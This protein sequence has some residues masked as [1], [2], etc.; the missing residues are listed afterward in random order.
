MPLT[1]SYKILLVAPFGGSHFS[2]LENLASV[3]TDAGHSVLIT[4]PEL[5]ITSRYDLLQPAPGE[6]FTKEERLGIVGKCLKHIIA[7][8]TEKGTIAYIPTDCRS[9]KWRTLLELSLPFL[10]STHFTEAVRAAAPNLV[11]SDELLIGPSATLAA[12]LNKPLVCFSPWANHF[13]PRTFRGYPLL[14]SREPSV[15]WPDL[16]TSGWYV[17]GYLHALLCQR[18]LERW[19]REREGDANERVD[20]FMV[21]DISHFSYPHYI[22]PKVALVGG[23][24]LLG[25][26]PALTPQW[27]GK[28]HQGMLVVLS[29]GSYTDPSWLPWFNTLLEG[30]VSSEAGH[31]IAKINSNSS[32]LIQSEKITYTEWIP[33]KELLG[34]GKVS[35]FVSHCGQNSRLEAAFYGVP[36]LCIPL[37]GDQLMNAHT[38]KWRGFGEVL[39]KEELT[40][41]RVKEMVDGML[42]DPG[43]YRKV[44]DRAGDLYRRDPRCGRASFLFQIESLAELGASGGTCA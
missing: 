38:V 43:K 17:G 16:V 10:T 8:Q 30:I 41:G 28:A 2:V 36:I 21:N 4:C 39:L 25:G 33:Q 18:R 7:G 3:L 15:V 14:I 40:A 11:L 12:A 20:L 9:G 42:G 22:P 1:T 34:S 5:G 19:A 13:R 23:L 32:N 24:H 35:L 44:L 31:V 6:G 27:E 37:F 29:M 26:T